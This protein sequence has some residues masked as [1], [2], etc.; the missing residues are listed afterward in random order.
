M[1]ATLRVTVHYI[2]T[3]KL[4]RTLNVF[5]EFKYLLRFSVTQNTPNIGP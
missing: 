3:H 4:E 5:I 2:D 1:L